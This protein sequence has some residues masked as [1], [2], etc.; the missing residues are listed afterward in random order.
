MRGGF[1]KAPASSAP[2][3]AARIIWAIARSH[4]PDSAGAKVSSLWQEASAGNPPPGRAFCSK[5]SVP[6]DQH[7]NAGFWW[8]RRPADG[9]FAPTSS[10]PAGGTTA[11]Q[12]NC[13]IQGGA[14]LSP[15]WEGFTIASTGTIP[16]PV[17]DAPVVVAS[18]RPAR[19]V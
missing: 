17:A 3:F 18:A 7:L 6:P 8:P 16:A 5:F 15:P 2:F 19:M 13:D 1:R 11:P 9:F 10:K 4:A 14:V 12:E